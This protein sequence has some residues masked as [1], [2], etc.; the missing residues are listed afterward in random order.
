MPRFQSLKKAITL[1]TDYP[2]DAARTFPARH[3]GNHAQPNAAASARSALGRSLQ[4]AARRLREKNSK[5][6]PSL[7]PA[8][9][10]RGHN[11]DVFSETKWH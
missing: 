9:H 1:A 10:D 5:L 4:A 2:E 11:L 8:F 6:W 7:H 3:Q